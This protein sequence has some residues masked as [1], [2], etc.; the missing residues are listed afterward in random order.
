MPRPQTLRRLG[1]VVVSVLV[2][3]CGPD[4]AEPRARPAEPAPRACPIGPVPAT[5]VPD[6]EPRHDLLDTWLAP[7]GEGAADAVLVGPE[8]RRALAAV[9]GT[10]ESAWK[11]PLSSDLADPTRLR[12]SIRDRFGWMQ[13]GLARGELV[14]GRPGSLALAR[15]IADQASDVD[16]VRVVVEETPL[17]CVP[18]NTGV[19]KLPPDPAFDR[20]RCSSL[21]PAELVRVLQRGPNGDWLYVHAGYVAGWIHAPKLTPRLARDAIDA[22]RSTDRI[23]PLSDRVTT[24]DGFRIRLGTSVPHLG[25]TAEG[26]RV[27]VPSP[28]G[29]REAVVPAS[30]EASVGFPPLT[31]RNVW[32]IALGEV[33]SP[34]GWGGTGG[35]RDCSRFLRDLF[36]TFGIELPRHSADQAARG[37]RVVE[38]DGMPEGQKR[39][40]I[41]A[42]AE[43]GVLLLYMPGHIMLHLGRE[44]DRHYAISALSEY[45]TPCP[46][47]PDTVHRLDRVAVTPL[48]LGRGT[49]RTAFIERLTR[50]VM[51]APTP[52]EAGFGE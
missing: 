30:A 43:E 4:P 49:E 22:W 33:G 37:T 47:G 2:W 29:L 23:V 9:L 1:S 21:H 40:V 38:L 17:Y 10:D 3:G 41:D 28:E 31:R 35:H 48:D 24:T 51:F 20:N 12:A 14:E 44:G 13:A 19:Y 42:L 50:V 39:T 7:L 32:S 52:A 16:H 34:Y 5:T 25:S 36:A 45:L 26:H 8:H 46:G 18:S 6:T 11:D 15:T 27:L